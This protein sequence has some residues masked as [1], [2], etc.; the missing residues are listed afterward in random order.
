MLINVCSSSLAMPQT[1]FLLTRVFIN[2]SL[3]IEPGE[4]VAIVG[5]SGGGKTTIF[6]L[7]LRF[8]DPQDG[9]IAFDDLN[10]VRTDPRELRSKIGIVTQQPVIFDLN[11]WETKL[12][13]HPRH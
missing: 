1:I 8:Y 2:F 13:L 11:V 4:T 3:V 9:Y 10:I 6:Q 7:I 5:P 12:I